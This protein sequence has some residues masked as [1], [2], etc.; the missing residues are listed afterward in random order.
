MP[1]ESK[2]A[3]RERAVEVC[4]RMGEFYPAA[5]PAL[6]FRTPF[7][8]VIAVAL[9]AQT[10]DANV[11]KVTPELFERFGT[12]QEMA[13]ADAAEIE[14]IIHSIGF[15]RNKARNCIACA[16][17][18]MSDFGGEVPQSMEELQKLPGVG[19]KTANIVMN[20]SFGKCEGIAVDTHVF[21][22]AHKLKLSNKKTPGET[23]EDLLDLLPREL[24]TD[25]NSQWI[26]FGRQ[27]CVARRPKC[28][29]CPLSDL[30]PSHPE[31]KRS[32][33]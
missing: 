24:W 23:E 32:K 9:S 14:Q 19:R 25:V 10:T 6:H 21:R 22:I 29:E 33:G 26:L 1:R 2:K 15:Y 17:M 20:V 30:C 3:K 5:D 12:P 8:C 11:N 4:R 27:W 18:I 31:F 7:E 28:A 16:Q 13:A